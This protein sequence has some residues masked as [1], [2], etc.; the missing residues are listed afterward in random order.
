MNHI[1]IFI[2]ILLVSIIIMNE[3]T[4]KQSYIYTDNPRK[5]IS[6][7]HQSIQHHK[8]INY[9]GFVEPEHKLIQ[10][11][12]GMSSGSKI[13]LTGACKS[14]LYTKHTL[15]ETLQN[16]LLALITYVLTSLH[17]LSSRN[18]YIKE[19]E[20]A[21]IQ[22]DKNKNR[23]FILDF[24]M[25]DVKNYYSVRV[26]C[27]IV[28]IDN[29]VYMN[30]INI[31]PTSTTNIIDRYNYKF[32]SQGILIDS[33]MFQENMD[34]LLNQSYKQ[35]YT[36]IGVNDTNND[37][38]DLDLSSVMTLESIANM[39]LP[40]YIKESEYTYYKEKELDGYL[41]KYYPPDLKTI[42]S[43]QFCQ[44][45]KNQEWDNYG[46]PNEQEAPD[47]CITDHNQTSIEYNRPWFGPGLMYERS[48]KDRYSWLKDPE[49]GNIIR[50]QGY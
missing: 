3:L 26:V 46:I 8:D 29:I 9:S 23:R 41:E 18:Y 28:I 36:I 25:Y 17:K 22:I 50:E 7:L 42:Q 33:D 32:N 43:P 30:Y 4:K 27:D 12:Q 10:V 13:K 5:T 31:L 44:K 48:S 38:S 11:L 24:F 39:Y 49:R 47:Y 45:Y 40:T 6:S 37:Y 14:L 15:T 21:Y 1:F 2:C 20:N 35:H 34:E 19:I 16:D